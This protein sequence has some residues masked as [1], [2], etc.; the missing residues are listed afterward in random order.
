MNDSL[1]ESGVHRI[2]WGVRVDA[3][4]ARLHRRARIFCGVGLVAFLSG[5][6]AILGFVPDRGLAGLL[7][8]IYFET[9]CIYSFTMIVYPFMG[10][11]FQVGLAANRE[12]LD[13]IERLSDLA[14]TGDHPTIKRIEDAAL[15]AADDMHA[16]R[17]AIEKR[18]EPLP[19]R[20]RPLEEVE[21]GGGNGEDR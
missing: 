14:E 11:A 21:S 6:A 16:V 12:M 15:R 10:G 20:R 1:N 19:V 8:V 3:I 13:K 7:V 5:S 4:L 2:P 18:T 17:I 9:L